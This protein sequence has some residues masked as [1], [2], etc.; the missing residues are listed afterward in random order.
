MPAY[1]ER[2]PQRQLFVV[3]PSRVHPHGRPWRATTE[4]YHGPPAADS[5]HGLLPHLGAP[6]R[7]DGDVDAGA[8]R[9][10]AQPDRKIGSLRGV[11]TL[12]DAEPTH[13][14]E[15]PPRLAYEDDTS[16]RLRGDQGEEAAERPVADHRDGHAALH[17]PAL[18]AEEGAGQRLGERG[19]LR[20]QR[21]REA[22]DVGGHE[23]GRQGDVL[24][25]G[26]VDE[27]K[28]LAEVLAMHPTEAAEA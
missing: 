18:H 2:L 8:A 17:P 20:G 12:R 1:G 13:L 21:G 27:E 9:G 14:I 11:E 28:V 16:A 5:R 25:V 6:R 7:V 23:T 10:L 19:A 4:E 3:R 15:A 22:D 26:P 24:A